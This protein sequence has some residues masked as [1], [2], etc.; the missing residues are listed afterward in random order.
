[1]TDRDPAAD[2]RPPEVLRV[3]AEE[4][5]GASGDSVSPFLDRVLELSE[6]LH[7]GADLPEVGSEICAAVAEEMG[8][9]RVTFSTR[10]PRSGETRVVAVYGF[11]PEE[12]V[13]ALGRAPARM[14]ERPWWERSRWETGGLF[15]VPQG[16]GPSGLGSLLVVPLRSRDALLG[17]LVLENPAS[18]SSRS[19]AVLDAVKLLGHLMARSV[20]NVRMF[21]AERGLAQRARD[22]NKFQDSLLVLGQTILAG[23]SLE[24]V[25]ERVCETVHRRLGW[26]RVVISVREETTGRVIASAGLA[27][28]EAE[29]LRANRPALE[30]DAPWYAQARFQISQSYFVPAEE[31]RALPVRP[32]L[33][34][35]SGQEPRLHPDAWQNEDFLIVPLLSGGEQVGAISVDTPVSGSR[36]RFAQIR[37]LELVANVAAAAVRNARLYGMARAAQREWEA[38][39]NS[40]DQGMAVLD[41]DRIITRANPALPELLGLPPDQATG[42][43]LDALVPVEAVRA[44]LLVLLDAAAGRGPADP[45]GPA[46][47]VP[48]GGRLLRAEAHRMG[49]RT[50]MVLTDLTAQGI[51]QRQMVQSEKM[52]ALGELMRGVVHDLHDP[53][54]S[55]VGFSQLLAR[56]SDASSDA[57]RMVGTIRRQAEEASQIVNSLLRFARRTDDDPQPRTPG[58]LVEDAV[59]LLSHSA[60]LG[61]VDFQNEITDDLPPVM[62]SH[63]AVEQALVGMAQNAVQVLT[64]AGGGTLTLSAELVGDDV[65]MHIDD[66]GPGVPEDLRPRVFEPFFTTRRAEGGSGLGLAIAR[67]LV[68]RQGGDLEVGDAPGGGARFTMRFARVPE[69]PLDGPDPEGPT[70]TPVEEPGTGDR[71][72]P[73]RRALVAHSI[74]HEAALVRGVLESE[75]WTVGGVD[76]PEALATALRGATLDLLL[77]DLGLIDGVEALSALLG[78]G[79]AQSRSTGDSEGGRVVVLVGED[80]GSEVL[81]ALESEGRTYLTRPLRI[82]R[83]REV[84]G[85]RSEPASDQG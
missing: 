72:E 5:R 4:G 59:Q 37:M 43:R 12:R 38:A 69:S 52:M 54:A 16:E 57:E 10:D 29:A 65:L 83:L 7:L 6:R 64:E 60:R 22:Q 47:E 76:S 74:P 23:T 46:L 56:D 21:E 62:V 49:D 82:E 45:E 85:S 53:L 24:E 80:A 48:L 33:V 9:G 73:A 44:Q 35:F 1:M 14:G 39:F 51:V 42:T 84:A 40:L 67:A 71:A 41:D 75:G 81:E 63:G 36:P 77:L 79:S 68:Q 78:S 3:P 28:S 61:G 31:Y 17:L 18:E 27:P 55:V 58:E 13:I 25:G 2:D 26:D 19:P 30:H 32:Q 50:V 15:F 20:E 11:S 66:S 34:F 8:W 70:E